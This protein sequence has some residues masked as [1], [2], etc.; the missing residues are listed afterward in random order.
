VLLPLF[1]GVAIRFWFYSLAD[2][3]WRDETKLLLNIVSK[4]FLS[5]L[6]QLDYKQEA[7]IPLLWL[8][9]F[10]YILGGNGELSM[11]AI[12]LI[13]N[14]LSLY[15][16]CLITYRIFTETRTIF[17]LNLLFALSPGI[18]LFASSIKQ[19]SLDLCI[20]SVLLYLA[21]RWVNDS[22]DFTCD[23]KKYLI[24]ALA[25]WFSYPSLFITLSIGIALFLKNFRKDIR[26]PIIFL[27][28]T[29]ISF[30]LEWLIFLRRCVTMKDH[31]SFLKLTNLVGV[32]DVLRH[33]FFAYTGPNM[34][35]FLLFGL[36]IMASL[37]LLGL[38]E[39]YRQRV[40]AWL[41]VL[42]L[43]ILLSLGAS[44]TEHYPLY[45]RTL[46][47]ATP[48]LYLLVG[49]GIKVIVQAASPSNVATGKREGAS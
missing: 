17:F 16:F 10:I 3:F 8:L 44:L 23:Y 12:S 35:L 36:A 5:L 46:L 1:I 22:N 26:S 30:I 27:S 20:A 4:S 2:S 14:I 21:V 33:I 48:G 45:G 37:T 31:Q 47:F 15:F 24:A 29:S 9:K 7:P 25:S 19:Y 11:R 28:V 32:S 39:A 49:Y 42:V 43:P 6:G 18:I 38:I 40:Y 41:V 13:T 34:S